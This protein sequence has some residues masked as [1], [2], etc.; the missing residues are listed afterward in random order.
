MSRSLIFA[1]FASLVCA[2]TVTYDFDIGWVTVSLVG[3]TWMTAIDTARLPP[4]DFQ[5]PLSASMGSGRQFS[6]ETTARHI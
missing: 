5:D 1:A 4:M 6:Q 3:L 2:K